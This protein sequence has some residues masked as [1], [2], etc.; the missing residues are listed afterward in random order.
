MAQPKAPAKTEKSEVAQQRSSLS[1]VDAFLKQV[2]GLQPVGSGRGRLIFAMDATMSRQP[3]W[4][5]ALELQADMFN[6]VKA[7]GGLDV[8][9]VY[10]RGLGECQASKWVGDPDALARLMRQVSCAG[11]YTQIRKVLAHARRESETSKANALIYVGDCMEED[12][13][14]L[15]QLAGELGL[16]GVPVF[17]F[18]EGRDP[19]AKR[20]F[21]EIAR[22]SRG[23]Y[24]PFDAGS[25]RQLRE[26]LTAVAVYA[27]GGRKALKDFGDETR[28]SAAI[29]L[30]EQLG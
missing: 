23:A 14:E 12:V 8:Q 26:L 4:D 1:E 10:F 22:L 28:S 17:V 18:Q 21:R 11:G 16:I 20:A 13:D 6:A 29:R 27:T 19:K 24:C 25:A 7:V 30:L 15:S 3:S 2:K 9:L 5:L